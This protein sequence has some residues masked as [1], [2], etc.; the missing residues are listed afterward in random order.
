MFRKPIFTSLSI[1]ISGTA[2]AGELGPVQTCAAGDVSVPCSD[3]DSRVFA[4]IA[5][6][7]NSFS[8][9]FSPLART[10]VMS[11]FRGIT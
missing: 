1:A 7:S 10:N 4:V 9:R 8:V 6:L 2:I 11:A 3:A 5:V